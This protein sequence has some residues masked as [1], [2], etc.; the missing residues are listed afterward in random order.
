[1]RAWDEN[2]IDAVFEAV[3]RNREHL[4]PFMHWMTPDYSRESTETFLRT[5]IEARR[6]RENLG[7]G[8]WQGTSLIGSIGFTRFDW[9][10]KKTEIGYWIDK[11]W[12]GKGI[13]TEATKT[14]IKYAFDDL[15]LNRIEIHC[16]TLN[17]RS[18]AIPERLGFQK[19]GVLR[20]SEFRN[21][22]LHDFAI[23]GLLADDS[24][25]W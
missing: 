3:V 17:A 18:S 13:V 22:T 2:D 7:F 5:S 14:L 21:G 4:T 12:E 8:L 11:D 9:T 19:E 1:M 6:R 23:Y 24:R 25:V 20:R 10:S 16:S 15:G